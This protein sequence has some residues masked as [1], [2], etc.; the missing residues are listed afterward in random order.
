MLPLDASWQVVL[1]DLYA[2]SALDNFGF[3]FEFEVEA[4]GNVFECEM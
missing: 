2:A 1:D 3:E 4:A